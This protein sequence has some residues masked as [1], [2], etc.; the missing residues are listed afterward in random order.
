MDPRSVG[1]SKLDAGQALAEAR[2]FLRDRGY[3]PMEAV[4]YDKV[5]NTADITFVGK[6]NNILIYPEKITVKVALDN[7]EVIGMQAA[8]YLFEH[9]K[10]N[11]PKPKMNEAA[12]RKML[13][14]DFKVSGSRLAL[15]KNDMDEEVLCYEFIGRINGSKYRLLINA[16]TGIE[17]TVEALNENPNAL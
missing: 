16:D 13:N 12:A 4:A 7:G 14:P 15:I 6:Q 9:K 1:K 10:R 3:T 2:N 8:D 11:L 5:G 17:E